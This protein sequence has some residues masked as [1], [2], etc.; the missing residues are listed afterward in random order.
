MIEKYKKNCQANIILMY[1][2]KSQL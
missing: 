2:Q 1:R